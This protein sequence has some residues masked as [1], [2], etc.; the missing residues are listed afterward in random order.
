[1]RVECE[2]STLTP[3]PLFKGRM[4]GHRWRRQASTASGRWRKVGPLAV[5]VGSADP[6]VQLNF[7]SKDVQIYFSRDFHARKCSWI[8]VKNRKGARKV[9][10]MQGCF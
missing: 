9:S 10:S 8:F 5:G 7:S 1:M 3:R 4:A 2:S 6:R